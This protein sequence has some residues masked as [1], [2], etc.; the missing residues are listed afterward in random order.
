MTLLQMTATDCATEQTD[1][2]PSIT[3]FAVW[4]AAFRTLRQYPEAS[5]LVAAQRADTAHATG[6]TFKFRFWGCVALALMEW[7]REPTM[8][9]AM[10]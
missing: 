9:D 7:H 4:S 10:N 1:I 3:K 8:A 6:Q 5:C 2:V